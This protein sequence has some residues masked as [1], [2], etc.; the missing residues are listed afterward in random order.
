[1]SNNGILV[2]NTTFGCSIWKM[3]LRRFFFVSSL[4]FKTHSFIPKFSSS[5]DEPMGDILPF[6]FL[7]SLWA[8]LHVHRL[9]LKC[10]PTS[11]KQKKST[12]WKLKERKKE[13]NK[14]KIKSTVYL[15]PLSHL[16]DGRMEEDL[17]EKIYPH[18]KGHEET[19]LCERKKEHTQFREEAE[20]SA[21][22]IFTVSERRAWPWTRNWRWR[23]LAGL[24]LARQTGDW[25]CPLC[26]L[27][28]GPQIQRTWEQKTIT[29]Q[30]WWLAFGWN[31]FNLEIKLFS[32]LSLYRLRLCFETILH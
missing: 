19:C 6:L 27:V 4:S 28:S 32:T 9:H 22:A 31:Y 2:L 23:S 30:R 16:F 14:I 1:M 26:F 29:W 15:T 5:L 20:T 12:P 21:R 8:L 11:P 13:K 17:Y 10:S 3:I 25:R 18:K 7:K 24:A